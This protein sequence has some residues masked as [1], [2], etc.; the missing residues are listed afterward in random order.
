MTGYALGRT[1]QPS[2]EV[3]IRKI[4]QMGGGAKSLTPATAIRQQQ[5]VS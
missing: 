1:V 2:D 5:A 4:S 3:L